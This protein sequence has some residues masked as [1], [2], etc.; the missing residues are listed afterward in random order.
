MFVPLKEDFWIK[1]ILKQAAV[2]VRYSL[3]ARI[4]LASATGV[5]DLEKSF[6]MLISSLSEDL[7]LSLTGISVKILYCR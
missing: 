5:V 1:D 3:V 4:T 2:K 6:K 7:L